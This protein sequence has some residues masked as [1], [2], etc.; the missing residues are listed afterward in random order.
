MGNRVKGKVAIA[1]GAGSIAKGM[2]NGKAAAILYAREGASV[3]LVDHNLEAAEETKK[4]INEEGG[5]CIVFKADVSKAADCKSIIQKC[6]QTYGRIDILHN[7]VGIEIPGGIDEIS[8]ED[9]DRTM[10]V[11]LKSM[12][13]TC[14]Y[15]LPYMEKQESGC[16][17]NIS[18]INAIRTLPALSIAYSASKAGVIAL[19][20]EIAAQYASKGIRANTV[21]P[22]L[23]NTPFVTA[24]LVGA[25]GGDIEEMTRIRDAMCPMGKQGDAWDVA[26]LSLFL[27][28]D[29]AKYITGAALIVDG[30]LTCLVRRGTMGGQ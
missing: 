12:F 5:N 30:G 26:Y 8:E 16:I 7:N 1:T 19:T 6:M 17:V 29:E 21:L 11:N 22:G 27:A 9:W 10:N 24:S 20:R 15:A 25:Y 13:L 14:K 4:L 28:S 18:S 3:V 23:M 2:G